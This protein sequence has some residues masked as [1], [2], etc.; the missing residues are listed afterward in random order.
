MGRQEPGTGGGPVS[1]NPKQQ[2]NSIPS[3]CSTNAVIL[4]AYSAIVVGTPGASNFQIHLL[5]SAGCHVSPWHEVPLY[6]SSHQLS[7]VVTTPRGSLTFY[8]VSREDNLN[9][10]RPQHMSAES[11]RGALSADPLRWTVGLLPQTY[12]DP[13]KSYDDNC[14]QGPVG[15]FPYDGWHLE[16]LDIGRGRAA[17]P[18]DVYAVKPLGAFT[19]VNVGTGHLCW[20][21]VAVD[22]RDPLAKQLNS[23]D[24]LMKLLPGLVDAIKKWLLIYKG[25]VHFLGCN[26]DMVEQDVAVGAVA[27]AHRAWRR[28]RERLDTLSPVPPLQSP[29]ILPIPPNSGNSSSLSD[30]TSRRLPSSVFPSTLGAHPH[31]STG[32]VDFSSPSSSSFQGS[33]SNQSTWSTASGTLPSPP[34]NAGL[35]DATSPSVSIDSARPVRGGRASMTQRAAGPLSTPNSTSSSTLGR[36]RRPSLKSSLISL[37]KPRKG[38]KGSPPTPLNPIETSTKASRSNSGS[39]STSNSSSNNTGRG[40]GSSLHERA[41]SISIGK[42]ED[43]PLSLW[44]AQGGHLAAP[45]SSSRQVAVSANANR[46]GLDDFIRQQDWDSPPEDE[47]G[48]GV[49]NLSRSRGV[50]EG[51]EGSHLWKASAS[52]SASGV[53]G[54]QPRSVSMGSGGVS[55]NSAGWKGHRNIPGGVRSL[56]DCAA[57]ETDYSRRGPSGALDGGSLLAIGRAQSAGQAQ[58]RDD[59]GAVADIPPRRASSMASVM[60]RELLLQPFHWEMSTDSNLGRQE[61]DGFQRSVES[62]WSPSLPPAQIYQTVTPWSGADVGKGESSG[63]VSARAVLSDNALSSGRGGAFPD[64]STFARSTSMPPVSSD[65]HEGQNWHGSRQGPPSA[66]AAYSFSKQRTSPVKGPA[67]GARAPA[68]PPVGKESGDALHS[69]LWGLR[70]SQEASSEGR[71]DFADDAPFSHQRQSSLTAFEELRRPRL[72]LSQADV[73]RV[74]DLVPREDEEDVDYDHVSAYRHRRTQS[75]PDSAVVANKV[76]LAKKSPSLPPSEIPLPVSS[77]RLASKDPY[78]FS[79][80]SYG[81]PSDV[82]GDTDLSLLRPSF[83]SVTKPPRRLG[84]LSSLPIGWSTDDLAE[85]TEDEEREAKEADFD[86]YE[87]DGKGVVV[88][89]QRG[90]SSQVIEAT[91]SLKGLLLVDEDET[92]EDEGEAMDARDR[93]IGNTVVATA[94]SPR[95]RV[96]GEAEFFQRALIRITT[97]PTPSGNLPLD[98]EERED[99]G[100]D[101]E[102]FFRRQGVGGGIRHQRQE[103]ESPQWPERSSHTAGEG[104]GRADHLRTSQR[105]EERGHIGGNAGLMSGGDLANRR[106]LSTA[107]LDR[108]RWQAIRNGCSPSGTLS[109]TPSGTP[110]RAASLS[111]SEYDDYDSTPLRGVSNRR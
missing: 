14:G 80:Q 74:G 76:M 107:H 81:S 42:K 19:L 50:G 20:K 103:P 35:V 43:T 75:L 12:G 63:A 58:L 33:S 67:S 15:G 22:A 7:I 11:P 44:T 53:F 65:R 84:Q 82:F 73:S 94:L 28:L 45:G 90:V 72:D 5:N 97:P 41:S 54:K 92:R 25:G 110:S 59:A 68:F 69:N 60:E 83:A 98:E 108:L 64:E 52:S 46:K 55:A 36:R 106:P 85:E 51:V 9:C 3:S 79:K 6:C 34:P 10:I 104:G 111:G 102:D 26:G 62:A 49:Q 99:A 30:D 100:E 86:K 16:V 66:S 38:E 95:G 24:D 101:E 93:S 71:R 1:P 18:G 105:E 23:V 70:E 31:R 21:V 77:Q 13:E 39:S 40:K 56:S 8:N 2:H 29:S 37:I 32:S 57:T 89:S 78:V 91:G 88:H 47:G 61:A 96:S 48:E 109:G 17:Q 87:D 27:Q 4:E